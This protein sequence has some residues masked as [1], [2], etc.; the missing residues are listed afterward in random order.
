MNLYL[1][2]HGQSEGNVGKW[3]TGW[4]QCSL[5]EQGFEDARQVGE[6]LKGMTFDRIYS[7][8]LI[9]A[10]QTAQTAIPG[11]EP[12]ISPLLRE[13]S[14]G[15]LMGIPIERCYAEFGETYR[16]AR[17]TND[18]TAYGGENIAMHTERARQFMTL[19]E[20]NPAENIVAFTHAGFIEVFLDLVLGFSYERGRVH[21]PNCCIVRFS[22]TDR[23]RLHL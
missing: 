9:R 22:H 23:W 21:V 20:E 4:Q 8:D 12:V 11:C 15:S 17:V 19:L 5:T 18:F 10:I 14:V 3:H 7:S 1:V 6:K 2:R 13:R 16:N